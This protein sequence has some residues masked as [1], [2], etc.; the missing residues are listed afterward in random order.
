M[1]VVVN[2]LVKVSN[3][4]RAIILNKNAILVRVYKNKRG[5]AMY[6]K[7]SPKMAKSNSYLTL[8]L[9]IT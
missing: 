1:N 2:E 4:F 5:P 8:Y 9:Y 3:W 7:S 6:S